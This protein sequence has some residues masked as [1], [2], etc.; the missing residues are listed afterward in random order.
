[1]EDIIAASGIGVV[2]NAQDLTG[3]DENMYDIYY[4]NSSEQNTEVS[5]FTW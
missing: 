1:M 5:I 2:V 3:E 4:N